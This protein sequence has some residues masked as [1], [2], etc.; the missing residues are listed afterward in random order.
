MHWAVGWGANPIQIIFP[1]FLL[2]EAS[3]GVACLLVHCLGNGSAVV[4]I[5]SALVLPQLFFLGLLIPIGNFSSWLQWVEYAC[6]VKYGVNIAAS[7]EFSS[8]LCVSKTICQQWA[9]SLVAADISTD[10][11]WVYTMVLVL[12]FVVG[13]RLLG[14]VALGARMRHAASTGQVK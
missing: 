11:V 1:I 9:H 7:A 13:A 6:F 3:F 10:S 2:F 12:G 4:S 8:D 14:Q 5:G